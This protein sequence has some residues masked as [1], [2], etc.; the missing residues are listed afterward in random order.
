MAGIDKTYTDSYIEYKKF[1]TWAD[2]QYL[3]FFNGY[4]VCIGNYVWIRDEIDFSH[5][6][7]PIMNTPTWIDIYLIQ[8]CNIPFV[9]ER[10]KDVYNDE[11][12][13][14]FSSVD[15]TAYPPNDFKQNRRI[16]IKNKNNTKFPL[17][18][19]PYGKKIAW[20]LQSNN[21]FGYHEESKT[22]TKRGIYPSN[23]N[24]AHI[25]SI[26]SLIRH[27]RKQYLPKGVSFTISGIYVGEEYLVCIY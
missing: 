4:K 7:I 3:T 8:N 6:E 13:K 12:Y 15:L 1:K 14:E 10:M 22:W 23:T 25:S 5:G 20:W 18:S 17:H 19:K 26:K 24:T 9:L 2:T 27:L 16:V 21:K 11:T